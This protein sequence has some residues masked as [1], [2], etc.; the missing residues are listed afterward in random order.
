MSY[1]TEYCA[2]QI[3]DNL[4]GAIIICAITSPPGEYDDGFFG[5]RVKTKKGKEKAVWIQSDA[6][7]NGSGWIDIEPWK[8][9]KK[10]V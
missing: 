10:A 9:Q 3:M 6:E 5:F 7:G 8:E 1:D 2:K 4:I